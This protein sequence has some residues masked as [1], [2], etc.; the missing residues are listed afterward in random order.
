MKRETISQALDLLEERHVSAT[1][2]FDPGAIQEPPERIVPM[3]KKRILSFTLAAALLLALS[4]A[5]YAAWSVHEARQQEL[6]A[7][8]KIEENQVSSYHE[9]AVPDEQASGL[10]LLSAVNDG[11]VQRVYV[12]ISPVSEEDAGAFP[13]ETSFSWS[14][15]GTDIGGFAGPGLPAGLSLSGEKEIREAVL[16]YAYDR[17]TQTMTLECYID[18]SFLERAENALGTASL[19]L[20]VHMRSGQEEPVSFGPVFFSRTEK[21]VRY[22][23]FGHALYH[24]GETDREIEIVGLEL[25]PFS[26][27]WKVSYEGAESFHSPEADQEAYGPWSLLEDKICVEARLIFSDGSEFSTG[28]ALT[29]PYENGTVNLFCGWGSAIDIDDVQRIVLGDLVLWDE[30]S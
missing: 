12:N 23:D 21:Q 15:D 6:K 25:T 7:D 14:I 3:K 10:V 26:A 2:S 20:L 27:V 5:A 4:V 11:D 28:G 16:Q 19:P 24:E 18:L 17:E 13:K 1:A 9:Y 22:F 30:N 8:L 29:C